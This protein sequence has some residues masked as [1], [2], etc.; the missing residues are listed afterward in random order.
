LT[1]IHHNLVTRKRYLHRVIS[2]ANA[3]NPDLIVLTGDYITHKPERMSSVAALLGRLRASDG[4][5]ATLGN[6]DY[7][8]EVDD[9]RREFHRHGIELLEDEHRMIHPQRAVVGD[10][11]YPSVPPTPLTSYYRPDKLP[12][13]VEP[14]TPRPG[15]EPVVAEGGLEPPHERAP[16][17]S[18]W[19]HR[20]HKWLRARGFHRKWQE[21]QSPPAAYIHLDP[22]KHPVHHHAPEPAAGESSGLCVVGIGDL[23]EGNCDLAKAL[24]GA[25]RGGFRL[26]LSHNP[27][28][29]HLISPR[30]KIG[31]VLSGHT[32]GGQ[33]WPF[34]RS[35]LTQSRARRYLRGMVRSPATNVYISRG[36]GSS[37]L[38]FRWNC[39]PE[40]TLI[41]L[42]RA[43]NGATPSA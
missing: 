21:W 27:E 4:V 24:E 30:D 11:R 29:A 5:L 36:V 10:R 33:T 6:H 18:A 13:S 9:I 28:V 20:W 40:V 37:A 41:R 3:L 34:H 25:P 23:W 7:V 12:R 19:R 14:P 16:H 22:E 32:H 26:L 39:R 38:H 1:D 42:L 35:P 15:L 2:R 43:G 31:L 8:C 17:V